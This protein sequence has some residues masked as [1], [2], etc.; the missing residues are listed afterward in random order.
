MRSISSLTRAGASDADYPN[1]KLVDNPNG[2]LVDEAM[3]GDLLYNINKAANL[4]GITM[5][6]TPDNESNGYQILQALCNMKTTSLT[7]VGDWIDAGT[8][9][10][11]AVGGG[12]MTIDGGDV[13]Y[14]RIKFIGKTLFWQMKL[15]SVSVSGTV[16]SVVITPPTEMSDTDLDYVNNGMRFYGFIN[17]Q[18]G[19]I[20]SLGG[21]SNPGELTIYPAGGG[22]FTTGTNDQAYDFSIV[23][24]LFENP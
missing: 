10:V 22:N 21:A 20:V 11:T 2:T 17:G 19:L 16:S 4:A 1:G 13:D 6:E 15:S 9:S 7:G 18:P 14:N 5:N 23:A 12:S 8:P 24:E 3:L